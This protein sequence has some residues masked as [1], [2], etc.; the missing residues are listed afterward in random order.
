MADWFD[1]PELA[2]LAQWLD[3]DPLN[4]ME[5]AAQGLD[6]DQDLDLMFPQV[7]QPAAQVQDLHQQ[8]YP[9]VVPLLLA[10]MIQQDQVIQQQQAQLAHLAQVMG[11]QVQPVVHLPLPQ[12]HDQ[13]LD[14]VMA[15]PPQ[16]VD[17][18]AAVLWSSPAFRRQ[19]LFQLCN[20]KGNLNIHLTFAALE[21]IIKPC[22]TELLDMPITRSPNSPPNL[23]KKL[24]ALGQ[25]GRPV[26]E[27]WSGQYV[28]I[29]NL[30]KKTITDL[31][32]FLN[33]REQFCSTPSEFKSK[34]A[35]LDITDLTLLL[36]PGTP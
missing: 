18:Q 5:P 30:S 24:M 4:Q 23:T 12:G 14:Q 22:F 10:S 35:E 7:E 32:L 27:R 31:G 25:G 20:R 16:V 9:Q 17:A 8:Q 26:L 34:M 19:R 3:D 33:D 13:V 21:H 28:D 29:N 11:H 6:L 36:T 1:D 2:Q 15:Q